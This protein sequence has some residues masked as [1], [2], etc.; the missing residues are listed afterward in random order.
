MSHPSLYLYGLIPT[1]R[2]TSSKERGHQRCWRRRGFAHW[3][4]PAVS[5]SLCNRQGV[6]SRLSECPRQTAGSWRKWERL[7]RQP[8]SGTDTSVAFSRHCPAHASAVRRSWRWNQDDGSRHT[9]CHALL[10]PRRKKTRLQL[11][12][13]G[14]FRSITQAAGSP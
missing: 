2:R 9:R 1:Q 8:A 5:F 13:G 6:R 11:H 10:Q 14:R 12:R 4:P 7:E 3:E